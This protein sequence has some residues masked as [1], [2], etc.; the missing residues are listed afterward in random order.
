MP[1]EF[2]ADS[3]KPAELKWTEQ[4]P[5]NIG[6]GGAEMDFGTA[7]VVVDAVHDA[8]RSGVHGY[9]SPARSLATRVASAQW[10][11]SR[12]GWSVD[13]EMV[14]LVPDVVTALFRIMTEYINPEWPVMVMTPAYPKF[15][16]IADGLGRRSIGVELLRGPSAFTLDLERVEG[17]LKTEGPC[18]VVLCNPHN[19]T[20]S[21]LKEG[22]LVQLA[23]LVR[24]RGGMVISDE[25]HAPLA[26]PSATHLPFASLPGE[27]ASSIT[28]TITSASKA[29][30]ISGIKCAEVILPHRNAVAAWDASEM[31]RSTS[32]STST[33]G[34]VAAM[35]AYLDG[36]EW[37]DS[38]IDYL[39]GNRD[40]VSLFARTELPVIGYV[41]PEASY[42]SWLEL[43]EW[44]GQG[45]AGPAE[46]ISRAA[47]VS[48]MEGADFG[49]VSKDFV[50]LG[51]A[52]SWPVLLQ[53]LDRIADAIKGGPVK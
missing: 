5:A 4:G 35:A 44:L 41:E 45:N 20:G 47:R 53:A 37:L 31:L 24:R 21:V 18:L 22:E 25:V 27:S 23:E 43:P 36:A 6:L 30:N 26:Y 29:W 33:L 39:A 12:Y 16:K 11:K 15:F 9:L 42:L 51:F 34:A 46:F 49:P 3:F 19:P 32:N 38:V 17:H 13:P 1:V 8:L 50:R 28:F 52:T 2:D 10:Q 48:A 40:V 14:R 7:P